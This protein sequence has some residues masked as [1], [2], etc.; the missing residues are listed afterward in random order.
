MKCFCSEKVT[1]LQFHFRNLF[2]QM[3]SKNTI[4]LIKS[5]ALKK[6]RVKQNLFLVE[7]DK[8]VSE[9]LESQFSVENLLGTSAFLEANKSLLTKVKLVTEVT[10]TEIEEAS[11]LKNPQNS[12]A[13][14]KLPKAKPFPEKIESDLCIYLDDIQDPGN[15]GTIIR[16]CDWFG[17]NQL[18]CSPKT[19]DLFNPKVIQASM[20]SFSRVETW[21]TPFIPVADLAG[22]L[23]IPVL[24]AF[25][26]GKNIYEQKLPKRAILVLGNEGNGISSEVENKVDQKI[27][28]PEFNNNPTS[29]ESLNVSV[30]AAII[31]SEFKRQNYI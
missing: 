4:K 8:N 22:R 15:L 31:C 17:I 10:K 24:G 18:F 5:L 21:N 11:L 25:L 12:I 28:I 2:F 30:A 23:G 29:A 3:V 13:I 27:R 16:I 7:G 19:A 20:G 1:L 6:N 14:C 9:V 26:D